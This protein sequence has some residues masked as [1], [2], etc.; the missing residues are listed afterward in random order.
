[1]FEGSCVA[2]VTPFKDGALDEKKLAELV[3]FQIAGGTSCLVPCGTTGESPALSH[4]EHGR[5]VELTVKFV[6][7]RALVM[8]GTGSNSTREAAEM[9]RHAREAGADGALVVVPYY[10]KPTPR[11][12]AEHFRAVAR[13]ASLPLVIYNI[14]SRTGVNM[15]P[16]SIIELARSEKTI[17]GVKEASGN[18]DQASE[19]AAALP[20]FDVLSGDDSLTLPILSVGGKGVISVL[21]N[22]A[23]RDV[24]DLCAA[25]KA[26]DPARARALHAKM[27]PLVKALF[28]ET[29]PIPLKTAMEWLGLCSSEMRLPL[30]PMEKPAAEKL[31]KALRAYGLL[32][33]KPARAG[34]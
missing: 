26:G 7:K 14:P 4:Q 25:W 8:A 30:A 3:E 10:N 31:E 27:F 22:I 12:L 6:R 23:P 11:G 16:S 24:A 9:T 20:D 29:N 13:A 18:L 2:L 17:V 15:A 32:G 21:A 1:M 34:C 28:L 33:P 5:V 19:I